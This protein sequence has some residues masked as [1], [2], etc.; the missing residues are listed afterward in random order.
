V[1]CGGEIVGVLGSVPLL[2]DLFAKSRGKKQR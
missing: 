1:M 2:L